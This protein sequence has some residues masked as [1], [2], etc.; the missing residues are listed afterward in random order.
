MSLITLMLL[1]CFHHGYAGLHLGHKGFQL[2]KVLVI[3]LILGEDK[4]FL[5]REVESL[6][7]C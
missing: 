6:T 1:R 3:H 5:K 7:L 2:V 4:I